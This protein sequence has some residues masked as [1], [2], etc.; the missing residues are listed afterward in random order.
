[1]RLVG[2]LACLNTEQ[3]FCYVTVITRALGGGG[4][5]IGTRRKGETKLLSRERRL[6]PW[7]KVCWYG[8]IS[9]CNVLVA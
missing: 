5:G 3:V 4:G 1:V 8:F 6:F 7:Q 9:G 2:H